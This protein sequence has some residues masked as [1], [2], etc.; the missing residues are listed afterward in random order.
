M[1]VWN[2]LGALF[3]IPALSHYLLNPIATINADDGGG[4]S[5]APSADDLPVPA[6]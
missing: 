5:D 1:F 3:L 4:T 2:M 6:A